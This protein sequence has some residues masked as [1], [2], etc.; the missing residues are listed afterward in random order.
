[1]SEQR[2]RARARGL[3][4]RQEQDNKG[5]PCILTGW[6]IIDGEHAEE[7]ILGRFYVHT[8]AS[9]QNA[10]RNLRAA[11][12]T[13]SG[14]DMWSGDG[15]G[16]HDVDV[17]IVVGQLPSGKTYKHVEH[18]QRLRPVD[19]RKWQQIDARARHLLGHR[20]ALELRPGPYPRESYEQR[21]QTNA[22][23]LQRTVDDLPVQK[24]GWRK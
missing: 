24:G 7:V 2:V 5:R 21:T 15:F 1:M 3:W 6:S 13:L 23:Q 17:E 10:L 8:D 18:V 16:E 14:P 12:C 20:E 4:M 11:G 22:R 19:P 9:L